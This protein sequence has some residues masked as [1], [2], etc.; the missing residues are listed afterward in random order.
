VTITDPHTKKNPA[1]S[2]PW[3]AQGGGEKREEGR[4][5]KKRKKGGDDRRAQRQDTAVRPA[6]R[7]GKY[8]RPLS[9]LSQLPL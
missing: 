3:G 9:I 5:G 6:C 1:P 4:E 8:P 7:P 2:A